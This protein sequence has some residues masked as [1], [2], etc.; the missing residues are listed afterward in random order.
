MK[1]VLCV[2]RN[3]LFE[4]HHFQ[5]FCPIKQHDYLPC[6][7]SQN[8]PLPRTDELEN[9]P[10]EKQMI[11]YA[12]II[13]PHTKTV[14]VYQ[15]T[16]NKQDYPEQ[17]LFSKWSA[18]IGGHIEPEG[19]NPITAAF[20]R[21]LHEELTMKHYPRPTIIGFVNH[22]ENVEAMHFGIV[23]IAETTEE[24]TKGDNEMTGCRFVTKTEFEKMMNSPHS[25]FETW[26]QLTWS[27]IRDTYLS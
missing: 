7:L 13:N 9:N 27:F 22:D 1:S 8:R 23:G 26:T 3:I 6:I 14:L 4:Q 12:W 20:D 18:G 15:R 17:R 11:T 10:Q 2:P 25:Q 24:V 19:E 16:N 5:G 21:E